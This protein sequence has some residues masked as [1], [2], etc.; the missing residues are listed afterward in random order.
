MDLN[1]LFRVL[2]RN[3]LLLII[4]PLVLTITVYFFASKQ[5]KFYSSETTIYTGIGSGYSIENTTRTNV[6]YYGT[7]MKFD[8]LINI[9]NS[10]STKEKT[11]IRLLAQ[12][13]CLES[14]NPQYISKENFDNLQKI[15]PKEVKDLVVKYGKTGAERDKIDSIKN[16]QNEINI[17][18]ARLNQKKAKIINTTN[19]TTNNQN[20]NNLILANKERNDYKYHTVSYG[21]SISSLASKYNISVGRLISMNKLK[22]T[23]IKPGDRII[24]NTQSYSQP[25]VSTSTKNDFH[26]VRPNE[27]LYSIAKKYNISVNDIKSWNSLTSEELPIGQSIIISKNTLSDNNFSNFDLPSGT[28]VTI[29]NKAT[30]EE[31]EKSKDAIVPPGVNKEDYFQTVK[32]FTEYYQS[33]DS[34]FIYELLQYH[35]PNYSIEAISRAQVSRVQNSDLI[36]LAYSSNEPGICQQTLKILTNVFI[37][38]Y[39]NIK[40]VDVDRV[41]QYF[42]NQVKLAAERLKNAENRLLRFNQDNNI[43]NYYEQS[44]YIAAQK[45]DLD[46]YYQDQQINIQ[47]AA[48]ALSNLEKKLIKKDSI[49]LK[50]DLIANKRKQLAKVSERLLINQVSEDYAPVTSTEIDHLKLKKK[51]LENDL[52]LYLDQLFMYKQSIEGIPVSNLLTEWLSNAIKYEEAKASLNVLQKRKKDFEHTY[53]IFAPLGATLKRIEREINV[54]EQ[55]YMELLKSHNEAKIKQQNLEMAS[56]IKVVDSPFYPLTVTSSKTKILMIAA[57]LMGFI[58]VA[59]IILVLEY[60]NSS[61][62]TPQKTT[63]KTGLKIAGAFPNLNNKDEN[64]DI[65]YAGNRLVEMIIQNMKLQLQHTSLN[66]P[67]KPYIILIFSTQ[68]QTGKTLVGHEI[69]NKL[70]SLGETV[71]YLNYKDNKTDSNESEYV[72]DI[73]NRFFEIKHIQELLNPSALRSANQDYDY[74]FLE[75]PSIIHNSYSLALMEAI[76]CPLLIIRASDTWKSADK[77]AVDTMNTVCNEQPMVILNEVESYVIDELLHGVPTTGKTFWNKLKRIIST[78]FRIRVNLNDEK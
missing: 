35:H 57:F 2:K 13:L 61:A 16:L 50:S 5:P 36:R 20:A 9:I 60:F 19:N 55:E 3:W 46:K 74:I 59:F 51:E 71:L 21:E 22:D 69:K 39:K 12:H 33:S 62:Q 41:A 34:N 47:S 17:L 72:Y 42:A 40:E 1:Q 44:K 75:I 8:N 64:I 78:P 14:Y 76:D 25:I 4:I 38:N 48:A 23:N 77:T 65:T 43:I 18:A 7:N 28:K 37:S 32:N 6:D 63:N 58:L 10:R 45:E 66:K 31:I 54:A 67:V 49:F 53:K 70:K 11:A 29:T 56:N 24:I 73:D 30:E 52:K 27:T 68:K 26:I 15:V